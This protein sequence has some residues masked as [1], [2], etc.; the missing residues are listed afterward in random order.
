[1]S[2]GLKLFPMPKQFI[3]DF[4][5]QYK[6]YIKTS[7]GYFVTHT[8]NQYFYQYDLSKGFVEKI[9]AKEYNDFKFERNQLTNHS[10]MAS[11]CKGVKQL[12]LF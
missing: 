9:S 2:S 5:Y 8:T 12:S 1:M 3:D 4:I 6:R 10:D 7:K 11:H